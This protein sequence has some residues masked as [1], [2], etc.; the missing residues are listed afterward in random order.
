MDDVTIFNSHCAKPDKP[1]LMG[2][3]MED[4]SLQQ[5]PL[6]HIRMHAPQFG[7]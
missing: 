5:S 3:W 2:E 6:Q 4:F 1:K 7:G